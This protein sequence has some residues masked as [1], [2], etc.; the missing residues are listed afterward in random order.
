MFLD[1]SATS[2]F[3]RLKGGPIRK[4][5]P[6]FLSKG[7]AVLKVLVSPSE[8]EISTL[9]MGAYR[10]HSSIQVHAAH[11]LVSVME[12]VHISRQV[13]YHQRQITDLRLGATSWSSWFFGHVGKVMLNKMCYEDSSFIVRSL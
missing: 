9:M 7:D 4:Y 11:R 12:V 5:I 13:W 3:L 8:K 2:Q 10:T 6:T 1:A